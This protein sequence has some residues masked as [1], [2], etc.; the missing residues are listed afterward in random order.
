MRRLSS[1][2]ARTRSGIWFPNSYG[3][4]PREEK[5]QPS[6]Y[7]AESPMH[8]LISAFQEKR[9]LVEDRNVRGGSS[10]RAAHDALSRHWS[11]AVDQRQNDG[12]DISL[13]LDLIRESGQWARGER[14]LIPS[15][16]QLEAAHS[17]YKRR[18]ADWTASDAPV[19]DYIRA[20]LFQRTRR[21]AIA[22]IALGLPAVAA[23]GLGLRAL[24]NY[25]ESLH[26]TRITFDGIS[27]PGPDYTIAAAPY[28]RRFGISISARSPVN[29]AVVIKSNIGLYGG[30]AADPT[31]SSEHFLTQENGSRN[32]TDRLY[33]EFRSP[34]SKRSNCCAPACGPAT[35]SGVTHPAWRAYALDDAGAE[36]AT[37]G[38]ALLASYE[39]VPASGMSC[40]RRTAR[41]LPVFVSSRISEITPAYRSPDSRLC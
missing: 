18:S 20:S 21:R 5:S 3:N 14:A 8:S 13:W 2:I 7:T 41:P 1:I 25:L 9:L 16:P 22:A 17:L 33:A 11:R 15:G 36:I 27:I 4:L 37:L 10:M 29:S 26:L 34:S 6:D 12:K 39:T 38:E 23:G 30:E 31:S 40:G 35:S 19:I 24:H 28:L 32:R